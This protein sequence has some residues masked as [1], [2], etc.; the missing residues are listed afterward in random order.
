MTRHDHLLQRRPNPNPDLNPNPNPY[1]IPYPNPYPHQFV[2]AKSTEK[3]DPISWRFGYRDAA[4][5]FVLLSEVVGATPPEPSTTCVTH[6]A[7]CDSR[8][9]PPRRTAATSVWW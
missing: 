1:P 7:K 6:G 2:A 8:V 4:D 3:R 9:P 5:S